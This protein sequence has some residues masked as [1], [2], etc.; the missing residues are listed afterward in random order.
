[1]NDRDL[2]AEHKHLLD[3]VLP[4]HYVQIIF[5]RYGFFPH[6]MPMEFSDIDHKLKL[7]EP[8][9]SGQYHSERMFN[10]GKKFFLE[11]LK[12]NVFTREE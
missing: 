2:F 9:E 12:N 6:N 3:K 4:P 11:C 8:R 5:L 7:Y 1:M 10:A